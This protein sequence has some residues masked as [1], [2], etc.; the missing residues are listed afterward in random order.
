MSSVESLVD[1]VIQAANTLRDLPP[2][3]PLVQALNRLVAED[4]SR[5]VFAAHIPSRV[6]GGLRVRTNIQRLPLPAIIGFACALAVPWIGLSAEKNR[7][8]AEVEILAGRAT[9]TTS[10]QLGRGSVRVRVDTQIDRTIVSGEF[11]SLLGNATEDTYKLDGPGTSDRCVF[12]E[13]P[14]LRIG[15][16]V[17]RNQRVVLANRP[18]FFSRWLEH[19]NTHV[20]GIVGNKVFEH[21]AIQFDFSSSKMRVYDKYVREFDEHE[22]DIRMAPFSPAV[23][24]IFG[25]RRISAV[26]DTGRPDA[27]SVSPDEEDFFQQKRRTELLVYGASQKGTL[28]PVLHAVSELDLGG[29]RIPN[30]TGRKNR[31]LTNIGMLT[32]SRFRVTLDYAKHKLYLKPRTDQPPADQPDASGL[33]IRRNLDGTFVRDLHVALP[34]Y[35]AGMREGDKIVSFNGQDVGKYSLSEM[36]ELLSHSGEEVTFVVEPAAAGGG[37]DGNEP[38][39]AKGAAVQRKSFTFKLRHPFTWPPVWPEKPVTKKP[40]PLD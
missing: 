23:G 6:E 17:V 34:A 29:L 13:V 32:L 33:D 28:D 25:E 8:V 2:P 36:Y 12:Y 19:S 11:R 7:P 40:I 15:S 10:V 39:A 24:L 3:E 30:A 18:K 20:D 1:Q 31:G 26:I 5:T 14:E 22:Y 37:A 4:T 16:F 35:L 27:F 21:T 9:P 38:V